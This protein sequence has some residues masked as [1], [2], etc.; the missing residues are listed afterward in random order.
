MTREEA[1][2]VLQHNYPS[3]CF[4][5]LCEAVEMAIKALRADGDTIS[6]QAAIDEINERQ[7]KLIYCFGFENDMVKIMDIA[8]SII[9]AMPSVIIAMPSAQQNSCEFWDDESN[10]CALHRPPVYAE[11]KRRV[12]DAAINSVALYLLKNRKVV[13]FYYHGRA[14]TMAV[15]ERSEDKDETD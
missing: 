8:R 3:A 9:I 13:R 14:Y 10:F 7:R 5:D 11:M 4:T 6:R 1:I 2:D 12:T 15:T